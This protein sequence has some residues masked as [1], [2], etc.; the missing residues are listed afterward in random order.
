MYTRQVLYH[1]AALP[2]LQ[3]QVW[4]Q[5]LYLIAYH[6]FPYQIIQEVI[7]IYDKSNYFQ[8]KNLLLTKNLNTIEKYK[9]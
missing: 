1:Q 6:T 8:I 7:F 4:N 3:V 9:E 5:S 2:A